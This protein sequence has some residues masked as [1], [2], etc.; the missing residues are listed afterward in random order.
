[1]CLKYAKENILMNVG[2]F[3]SKLD[4]IEKQAKKKKERKKKVKCNDVHM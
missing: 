4:P 2:V 3:W 1:V